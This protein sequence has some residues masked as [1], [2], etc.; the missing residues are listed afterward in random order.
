MLYKVWQNI[1]KLRARV[2][3]LRD[4]STTEELFNEFGTHKILNCIKIIAA[5]FSGL[6]VDKTK[7]EANPI[8]IILIRV[9][10][11]FSKFA[12]VAYRSKSIDNTNLKNKPSPEPSLLAYSISLNEIK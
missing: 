5:L 11:F 3:I 4:F 10:L 2:S 8:A 7:K 6:H 12:K 9:S 1:K